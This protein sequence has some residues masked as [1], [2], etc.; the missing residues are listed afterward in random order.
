MSLEEMDT[1]NYTL[2]KI[3]VVFSIDNPHLQQILL[4]DEYC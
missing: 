4:M 2:K 1:Q 3:G